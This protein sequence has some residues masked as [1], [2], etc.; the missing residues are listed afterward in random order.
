MRVIQNTA[1]LVAGVW[2]CSHVLS[3]QTTDAAQVLAAAREALGG[4]RNLT[5]IKTFM[6]TGRTRQLR[7]NNLVPIEFEISCELPDRFVRKDEI[8]APGYRPHRHRIQRRNLDP[9]SAT[10]G[11]P[12]RRATARRPRDERAGRPRARNPPPGDGRGRGGPAPSPTQQRL[13]SIKQDFARLMLGAF[14]TSF[15][16]YPLTFK[17]A[18][19]GEAPEGKADI[20]DVTGPGNFS[21]R[22]VVQRETHLPVMLIWQLPGPPAEYRM[23]FADFRDVNGVK[24]PFRIRRAIGANTIE[25]TTFDRVR[26][27]VKIDA[28]KFEVPK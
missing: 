1:L 2:A 23:V 10:A 4:D 7:G 25:E 21:G 18:A 24:W 22:F 3:G 5:A 26:F 6:A 9:V 12:R 14:A 28:R 27:N 17:Y 11:G 8:P 20:L 19:I 16:S 13:I 15:P